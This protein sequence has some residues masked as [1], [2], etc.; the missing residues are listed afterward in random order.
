ME[1]QEAANVNDGR[2]KEEERRGRGRK[3]NEKSKTEKD[4]RGHIREK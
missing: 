3:E 2:R 1:C 4:T